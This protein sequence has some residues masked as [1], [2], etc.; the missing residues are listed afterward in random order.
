MAFSL[1]DFKK[2]AVSSPLMIVYSILILLNHFSFVSNIL[3]LIY[4]KLIGFF[5]ENF[6]E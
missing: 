6:R 1:S 2:A 3:F 4:F 5:F